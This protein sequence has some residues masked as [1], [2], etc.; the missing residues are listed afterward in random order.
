[1]TY[2]KKSQKIEFQLNN[3]DSI[4]D[5]LKKYQVLLQNDMVSVDEQYDVEFVY[6][7]NGEIK[8]LQIY[9]GEEKI[10][11]TIEG[12]SDSAYTLGEIGFDEASSEGIF[13]SHALQYDEL[14]E[15]IV[16]TIKEIVNYS[17]RYNDTSDLWKDD[18]TVFGID[19][20][21]I[22]ANKHPE[23][24]YLLGAFVIPYWDTEHANYVL[25]YLSHPYHEYGFNND[26]MKMFCYCDNHEGRDAIINRSWEYYSED[27][28]DL[29]NYFKENPEKYQLFKDMLNERF[30]EQKFVQYSTHDYTAKPI[31]EFYKSIYISSAGDSDEYYD[32]IDLDQNFIDDTYENEAAKLHEEIE[33]FLGEPL[34]DPYKDPYDD[35]N[36]SENE[37]IW[38]DFFLNGFENGEEIWN[39]IIYGE[40]DSVLEDVSWVDIQ[41]LSKEKKLLLA[42]LID[43]HINKFDTVNE[44]FHEIFEN[45]INRYYEDE[46]EGFIV[47][48]N[49]SDASG[50]DLVIRALDVFYRLMNRKIF[51]Y[52]LYEL[53]VSYK[54]MKAK[55]FIERYDLNTGDIVSAISYLIADL[56][57]TC[58]GFIGGELDRIYTVINKNREE[59]LKLIEGKIITEKFDFDT[60]KSNISYDTYKSHRQINLYKN[61]LKANAQALRMV[62]YLLAQDYNN[63]TADDLTK[64][65]MSFIEKNWIGVYLNILKEESKLT[66]EDIELVNKYL[67]GRQKPPFELMMKLMKEGPESLTDEEK[68]L[69]NPTS[70]VIDKS[71][72]VQLLLEKLDKEID[73][74]D[75]QIQYEIFESFEEENMNTLASVLFL[76]GSIVP[77]SQKD[78]MKRAYELLLDL[79]PVRVIKSTSYI[80]DDNDLDQIKSVNQRYDFTRDIKRICKNKSAVLAWE[81]INDDD[82]RYK[83][84]VMAYVDDEPSDSSSFIKVESREEIEDALSYLNK[85]Y[86]SRFYDAVYEEDEDAI[87]PGEEK[88]FFSIIEDFIKYNVDPIEYDKEKLIEDTVNYITGEVELDEVQY[89][90]EELNDIATLRNIGRS[91]WKIEEEKRNRTILLL[92]KFSYEGIETGYDSDEVDIEEYIEILRKLE[93]PTEII[94]KFLIEIEDED[95]YCEFILS[96]DSYDF[97]KKMT[98]EDKLTALEMVEEDRECLEF[99]KLM[100]KD[101]SNKV[102]RIAEEIIDFFE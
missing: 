9:H 4:R 54:V 10:F 49:G 65:M 59:T 100:A 3:I 78:A 36:I 62:M 34:V 50:R 40:D 99:I 94:N 53:V 20:I 83:S 92:S 11:K 8:P 96:V 15:D 48:I 26:V 18:M 82:S 6:I 98:K 14:L 51:S 89:L 81:L 30:S 69:M 75:P 55:D 63:R 95:A 91:I 76:G 88:L 64:F 57:D 1:M 87:I 17:R 58:Y 102:K 52:G 97:V 33:S 37:D 56:F 86:K 66:D 77:S 32:E 101:E 12:Y 85:N 21:F 70:D 29:G 2:G 45:F 61:G 84:L 38:E 43:Y 7:D 46:N 80:L 60:I 31:E 13:F 24:Y 42:E 5:A 28:F 73:E 27:S 72:I 35:D 44:S 41:K 71:Q 74:D 93:I 23:Y 79:A 19:P 39:F 22:L 47:K 25:E 67:V 68:E 90:L 16:I